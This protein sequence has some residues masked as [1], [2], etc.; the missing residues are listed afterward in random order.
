MELQSSL[1]VNEERRNQS[2]HLQSECLAYNP[3]IFNQR[4]N[5]K[6]RGKQKD[7]T[8]RPHVLSEGIQGKLMAKAI[9]KS[10]VDSFLVGVRVLTPR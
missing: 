9:P 8:V 5:A 7:M 6:C 4:T 10:E 3:P 2:S 1:Q